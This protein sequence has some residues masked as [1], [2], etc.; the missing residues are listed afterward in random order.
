MIVRQWSARTTAEKAPAYAFHLQNYVFPELDP[1]EGYTGA[2][3]L[4]R[5][6]A[7]GGVEVVVLT[8]WQSFENIRAFSGDDL[9][10]A[11]VHEKAAALLSEFD[12]RVKHYELVL[13]S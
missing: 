5:D 6:I 12:K 8:F 1:L 13:K 11:V 2:M 3:L 9:E 4:Q 7:D 10:H